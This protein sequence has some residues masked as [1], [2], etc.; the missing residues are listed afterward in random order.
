VTSLETN[1]EYCIRLY[2]TFERPFWIYLRKE[3]G[4]QIPHFLF[5]FFYSFP[6]HMILRLDVNPCERSNSTELFFSFRSRYSVL[7]RTSVGRTFAVKFRRLRHRVTSRRNGMCP[8]KQER[9][10]PY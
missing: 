5:S 4:K 3:R 2:R 8:E 7:D 1:S 10:I 9:N 6:T